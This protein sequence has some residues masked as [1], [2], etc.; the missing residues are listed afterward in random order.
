MADSSIAGLLKLIAPQRRQTKQRVIVAAVH[1][2]VVGQR[3]AHTASA[4]PAMAA[5]AGIVTKQLFALRNDVGLSVLVGIRQFALRRLLDQVDRR[6]LGVV[7]RCRSLGGPPPAEGAKGC[8]SAEYRQ[9]AYK[10]KASSHCLSP[11][12]VA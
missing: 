3:R 5:A 1:P 12:I 7:D 11:F 2:G 10:Q 9:H 4:V 8:N 6:N